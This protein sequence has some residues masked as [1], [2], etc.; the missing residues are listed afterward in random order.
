MGVYIHGMEL[1]KDSYID[2]RLF[3][4][5]WAHTDEPPYYNKAFEAFELPP[6]GR[7]IDADVLRKR[8]KTEC[9]PYGKPTIGFDDGC[10]VMDMIDNAHTIIEAE[11]GD[12]Q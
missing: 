2:V 3:A 12:A 11:G 10:K 7:L 4:D 8:V 5:G 6:H 9:N 1:P